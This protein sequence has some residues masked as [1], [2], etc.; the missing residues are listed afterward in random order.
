[1]IVIYNPILKNLFD[2]NKYNNKYNNNNNK[3]NNNY[4]S[5]EDAKYNRRYKLSKFMI[6]NTVSNIVG[7]KNNI[8][9]TNN[10]TNVSKSIIDFTNFLE[11]EDT[12]P[13]SNY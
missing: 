13:C 7:P 10:I 3:Y 2:N 6:H 8:N 11:M 9:F 12:S 5:R 1:L 4:Y